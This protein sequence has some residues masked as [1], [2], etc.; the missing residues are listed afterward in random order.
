LQFAG[1]AFTVPAGT[2]IGARTATYDDDFLFVTAED[3]T[4]LASSKEVFVN[5]EALDTGSRYNVSEGTLV[6]HSYKTHPELE[7]VNEWAIVGG[8][9]SMTDEEMRFSILNASLTNARAN[10]AALMLALLKIPGVAEV[11]FQEWARGGGSFD[12]YIVSTSG[13]VT[14]SLVDEAQQTVDE[15]EAFGIRGTVVAPEELNVT[16]EMRVS[17]TDK[18]SDADKTTIRDSITT[19]IKSY[20]DNIPMGGEIILNEIVQR[21]MGVSELIYD[22]KILLMTIDGSPALLSNYTAERYQK[23]LA[24]TSVSTPIEVI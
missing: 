5:V 4:F 18:A 22:I 3:A 2:L 23:F 20:I 24:S 19:E 16:L 9:D 6:S 21:S 8:I 13:N 7:C 17:F 15:F 1:G 11:N 12:V 10:K 14:Q